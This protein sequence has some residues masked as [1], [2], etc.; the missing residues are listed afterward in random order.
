V[1]YLT[2]AA[3]DRDFGSLPPQHQKMFRDALP[4]DFLPAVAAGSFSGNH[5]WPPR[6]RVHQ[7]A[8]TTTIYS[9]TWNFARPGGRATFHL[10]T[11]DDE[12]MLVWRRIGTHDIYRRP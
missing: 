2:T 8:G 10:E 11:V 9:M 3:F 1:K 5:P 4:E 12:P 7:L 6:L